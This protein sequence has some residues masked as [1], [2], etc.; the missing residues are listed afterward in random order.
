MFNRVDFY[1][2]IR[3]HYN[4]R[5]TKLKRKYIFK[6]KKEGTEK[7]G[8]KLVNVFVLIILNKLL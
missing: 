6:R 8:K 4:W 1:F 5:N 2:D 3:L 7:L